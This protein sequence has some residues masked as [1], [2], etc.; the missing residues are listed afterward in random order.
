MGRGEDPP[1]LAKIWSRKPKFAVNGSRSCAEL[2]IV[3]HLRDQ[4]RHGV[5]V[6]S[7]GPRELRSCWFPAPAAKTLAETGA[8]TWAVEIFERLRTANGG[9]LSGFFDVFAWRAPSEVRFAEAKAGSDRIKP[10][11]LR[12]VELALR[13]H[14]PE[15]F[16]I[17]E[18]A[19]LSPCM[20][21]P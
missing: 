21:L 19:G 15:Q 7:F 11:Q 13:F 12:F 16:V 6:N 20:R 14:R 2:A 5:W 10:A 1:S 18:V 8:P 9:A 17:T 3:H 4:G